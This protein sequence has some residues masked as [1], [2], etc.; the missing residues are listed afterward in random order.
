MKLLMVQHHYYPS[1]GGGQEY[2]KLLSEGLVKKGH[3]VT[4]FTTNS[5]TNE[6]ILSL[7]FTP[8][9]LSRQKKIKTLKSKERVSG[10]S[11]KRFPVKGRF[12]SFNSIPEMFSS[13]DDFSDYDVITSYGFNLLSSFEACRK[14]KKQG[15]PFV[16]NGVDVLVPKT[17]PLPARALKWIYD[18]SFGRYLAKNSDYIISF[19]EDQVK[20]YVKRGVDESKI[21]IVPPPLVLKDYSSK[22][23]ES[24]LKRHGIKKNDKVLLYAGRITEHKGIQ[25]LIE[26]LPAIRKKVPTIKFFIAGGD[27][28]YKKTLQRLIRKKGVEDCVFFVGPYK[29]REKELVQFFAAADVFVL[30]SNMEGFGIVLAE[31]MACGTPCIAYN[32]PAVR[33]VISDGKNGYLAED[34]EDLKNHIISM[35]SNPRELKKMSEHGKESVKRLSQSAVV[36][37]LESIYKK[38]L[39]SKREKS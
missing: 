33:E 29:A 15:K 22:V 2:A 30:P 25:D 8:P 3:K 24:F 10:V 13:M 18:L 1:L 34:K 20:D 7:S 36:S 39:N 21:G 31:A 11:V 14:A 28:G 35:F 19:T 26:S 12:Y 37:N 32:I 16:L 5:L 23:S 6:D 4:V 27:Y 17:L 38:V 9:F